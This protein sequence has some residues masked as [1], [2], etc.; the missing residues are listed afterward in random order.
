M[1]ADHAKNGDVTVGDSACAQPTLDLDSSAQ[2]I[3]APEPG[4]GAVWVPAEPIAGSASLRLSS[5]SPTQAADLA[6]PPPARPLLPSRRLSSSPATPSGSS[7]AASAAAR[8]VRTAA[9]SAAACSP[10]PARQPGR[11]ARRR[12]AGS[13]ARA[14]ARGGEGCPTLGV[15]RVRRQSSA[16]RARSVFPRGHGGIPNS[17]RNARAKF[18]GPLLRSSPGRRSSPPPGALERGLRPGRGLQQHECFRHHLGPA[19]NVRAGSALC[20]VAGEHGAR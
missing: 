6:A 5:N 2:V 8:P 20:C 10:S 13:L 19:S 11:H 3:P 17:R 1:V 14:V 16:R 18:A 15:V 9:C 4:P 12:R 7:R